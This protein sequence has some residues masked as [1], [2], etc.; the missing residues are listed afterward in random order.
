M[1]LREYNRETQRIN[2]RC[3]ICGEIVA[4]YIC[5]DSGIP[6]IVAFDDSEDHICLTEEGGN[7]EE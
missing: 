4:E 7:D 3:E 6:C 2:L 5:N 1:F